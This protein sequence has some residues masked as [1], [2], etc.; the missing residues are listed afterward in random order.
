MRFPNTMF[1]LQTSFNPLLLGGGGNPLVEATLNA[2]RKALK[3]FE[4]FVPVT[5]KNSASVSVKGKMG[6]LRLT[7]RISHKYGRQWTKRNFLDVKKGLGE[8]FSKKIYSI[9][10]RRYRESFF[11]QA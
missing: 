11:F 7:R 4:T 9:L 2:R 10:G 1:T 5:S 6:G 8:F 3:T